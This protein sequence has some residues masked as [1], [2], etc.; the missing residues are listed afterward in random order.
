[1]NTNE[2]GHLYA[3]DPFQRLYPPGRLQPL[4]VAVPQPPEPAPPPREDLAA[5][6]QDGRVLPA[7]AHLRVF[8]RNRQV[9]RLVVVVVVEIVAVVFTLQNRSA[10]RS[11]SFSIRAGLQLTRTP[12]AHVTDRPTTQIRCYAKK[13]EGILA[14]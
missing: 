3:G 14:K 6:R 8:R 5:V 2:P 4:P 11:V 9:G 13:V 1:M 12:S 7:A 10:L